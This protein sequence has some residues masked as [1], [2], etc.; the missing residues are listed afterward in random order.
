[1]NE[2]YKKLIKDKLAKAV[3]SHVLTDDQTMA[4]ID[5]TLE[6]LVLGD[7]KNIIEAVKKFHGENEELVE[8]IEKLQ[9]K[10]FE[11]YNDMYEFIKKL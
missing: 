10:V 11:N 5:E 8:Q 2:Y 1:M 7:D 4:V 6:R 3:E 9:K